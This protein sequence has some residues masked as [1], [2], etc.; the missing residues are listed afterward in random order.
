MMLFPADPFAPPPPLFG[1]RTITV[2]FLAPITPIGVVILRLVA[3]VL[4]INTGMV[5]LAS[6]GI[7]SE[8]SS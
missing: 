5:S 7:N 6:I 1:A 4:A 8:M 2:V 3:N